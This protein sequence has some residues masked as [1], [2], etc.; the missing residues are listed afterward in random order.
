MR[1]A[2]I[3]VAAAAI[4]ATGCTHAQ[5]PAA[6]G[7]P[8]ATA[9][10]DGS[11]AS[12][13]R[14]PLGAH[15]DPTGSFVSYRVASTR[16]TRVEL[17]LYAQPLGAQPVASVAMTLDADGAWA[18]R[19]PAAQATTYYGYRAW[20]PNWP[21]DPA[22]T[23]G[24]LA[25]WVADVDRD[26]DRMNPNK[27]LVDP[28][29]EELSHDP[30][31]PA[32]PD[33]SAYAVGSQ[34]AVD[35]GPVAPKS[36]VLARADETGDVGA[37]PTRALHDDV[38][39]E[40]HVR[41][42]TMADPAAGACAGTYAGAAT[43][44]DYLASLG[45]TAIELTPI[46]ETTNDRND[47]DP[48]TDSGDNY[49]GYST[50]AYFAPDR[51]YAC[52]RSAGGPTRELRAMVAA[53]HARGI[54]VLV[55]VVYN[56]T[57]EGGGGSLLSLR[58]LDNAGYYQLDAGG[59][60]FTNDNGVGADVA[61]DKPLAQA[62]ILDSLA[63]WQDALGVDGF[64]FDLAPVLG[65][66]CGS[67]CFRFDPSGLPATIAERA[68]PAG[69][70]SG[71]DLI[72]EPWAVVSNGYEVGQFPVGWS[73][74]NDHIRDS[75]REDQNQAGV[76]AVTPSEL[77]TRLRGSPDLYG[78]RGPAASIDYLV[79]H[80]GF[81]LDDLYSCNAP[82]N[83]Q[84]WPFGPSDG[85]STTNH[86]WDH[87]GSAAA[88]RQAARTG[89]ALLALAQGVPM[90][91]GGDE[92]LRTIRCNNNSYDV[93]STAT[94]LDWSLATTNAD[95]VTFVQRL[96]AFRAAHAQ[97]HGGAW[98]DAT[99]LS[100]R[101]ATGAVASASYLGDATE[102]V[103]GWLAGDVYAVYNRGTSPVTVTLPAAPA[104]TTWY[105]AGDTSAGLE[106]DNWAAP[107]SEYM[108]HQSQYGLAA[109]AI[110]VFVGR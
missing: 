109:R 39:Y 47:I 13:D 5:M 101:D 33:A 51:R 76:V 100:F 1:R 86:S 108:M 94:W 57:A 40:V 49:W 17:E 22:W 59:S 83:A 93:D 97:L 89:M 110:A 25:G 71:V 60:G 12:P 107:G 52:D 84:P 35:S 99:A 65:N 24:S 18:A 63:Y 61:A 41:G 16:A 85:G 74:W 72:A 96:F 62:L 98:L 53:F 27:L 58:G 4:A 42:F 69:G 92:M 46:A 23:P 67:G 36:V 10:A 50:I 30:E 44:A 11:G 105:R 2:C 103:L 64:R 38:I 87:G 26:G 66:A 81:T 75:L 80:D 21:Y 82:S 91:T 79:S 43:R 73:E 15:W 55:D 70:G 88:Q 6:P 95:T 54:K 7:G 78:S 32:Q 104:G 20:G 90:I 9:P 106:P 3:I 77:A 19:V 28:Y 14:A 34:R 37:R 56:H 29:A 102:P 48:T 31:S 8:D 45:V 68:R